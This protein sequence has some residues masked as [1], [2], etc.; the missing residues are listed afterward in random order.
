MNKIDKII[1][2]MCQ[3]TK[4]LLINWEEFDDIALDHARKYFNTI[5]ISI[6]SKKIRISTIPY[7]KE[8]DEE[9]LGGHTIESIISLDKLEN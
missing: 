1:I 7:N 8:N 4:E 9:L 2:S 5:D 6:Y 3:F